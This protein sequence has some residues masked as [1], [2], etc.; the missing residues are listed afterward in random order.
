MQGNLD[1]HDSAAAGLAE[2]IGAAMRA[3]VTA[4]YQRGVPATVNDPAM[5]AIARQA[6]V[7]VVGAE[8]S[9]AVPAG[10]EHR[11]RSLKSN[12]W[13]SSMPWLAISRIASA[14][15]ESNRDTPM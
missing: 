14:V 2:G 4:A 8:P 3:E 12:R 6:A 7:E 9:G 1:T 5:A 13:R 11:P 15:V 10:A